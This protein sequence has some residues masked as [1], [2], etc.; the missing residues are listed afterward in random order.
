M[1][2]NPLQLL[3]LA[4][5]SAVQTVG[6][7]AGVEQPRYRT[8]LQDGPLEMREYTS[9]IVAETTV[10]GDAEAARNAGFRKVAAYIFG[11]NGGN[12]EV[13]MTSPVVQGGKQEIA[14]T[15]PVVQASRGESWT[16]QFVMPAKYSLESLPPPTDPDVK[17]RQEPAARYA[18]LRFTGSRSAPAVEARTKSLLQQAKA[19]GWRTKAAPVAWF[20]DPPWTLPPLRRNEVAVQVE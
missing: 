5:E 13:A 16:I 20:Y 7:R 11:A 15:A 1:S 14:M 17:L 6:I 4:L 18:V 9:R 12:Q 8:L 19:R 2:M 3:V 10:A